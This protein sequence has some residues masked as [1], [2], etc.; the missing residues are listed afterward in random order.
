MLCVDIVPSTSSTSVPSNSIENDNES[1]A[2]LSVSDNE[3]EYFAAA[4]VTDDA[5]TL[6]RDSNSPDIVYDDLEEITIENGMEPEKELSAKEVYKRRC[7]DAFHSLHGIFVKD[8]TS[9]RAQSKI[10]EFFKNLPDDIRVKLPRDARTL[11]PPKIKFT[12]RIVPP[13]ELTYFGI[14]N[15]LNYAGDVLFDSK[16][17]TISLRCNMD[18]VPLTKTVKGKKFWPILGNIDEYPVFVIAAYEGCHE[19]LCGNDYLRDFVSEVVKL[20]NQGCTVKGRV[21]RFRLLCIIC[22]S[23]AT[24]LVTGVKNHGGYYACRRCRTMGENLQLG[25]KNSAGK[26]K[27]SVRYPEIG[28]SS[29]TH[30]DFVEYARANTDPHARPDECCF[31]QEQKRIAEEKSNICD[32][33]YIYDLEEGGFRTYVE[34]EDGEY[35]AVNDEDDA[36]IAHDEDNQALFDKDKQIEDA[37]VRN[38]DN[39]DEKVVPMTSGTKRPG[40]DLSVGATRKKSK[41]GVNRRVSKRLQYHLHPTILVEIPGFDCVRD[42]ILD[43]MHFVLLGT[44]KKMLGRWNGTN[45]T[46]KSKYKLPKESLKL[47]SQRLIFAR[48]YCPAEFAREPD[49]LDYLSSYKGTQLRQILLYIGVVILLGV[50]SKPQLQ[51]FHLLV[52]AMRFMCRKLPPSASDSENRELVKRVADISRKLLRKFFFMGI[53]LYTA[54]FAL[55]NAHHIVHIADDYERFGIPLDSLSS[56]RYENANG[57]L[58]NL[59]TGHFQALSQ[60]ENK[61]SSMIHTKMYARSEKNKV[62]NSVEEYYEIPQLCHPILGN[63]NEA[64]EQMEAGRGF[65][66]DCVRLQGYKEMRLRNFKLRTDNERDCHIFMSGPEGQSFLRLKKILKDLDTDEI[67]LVG[68]KYLRKRPLFSLNDQ[69]FPSVNSQTA[70]IV[71]CDKLSNHLSTFSLSELN[72]KCFALPL[73]LMPSSL[74]KPG[75]EWVC[76][77]YLH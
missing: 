64:V 47:I 65:P 77:R 59:I 75:S 23:P 48:E 70:G 16:S 11:R 17:N 63:D 42:C 3:L 74:M 4:S 9:L 56:F 40:D 68:Y 52:V 18:G 37:A 27:N 8:G 24:C 44:L 45:L 26:P 20:T 34:G 51:H 41:C 25:G 36:H 55:Y 19:P 22:D 53:E 43:V 6:N 30:E 14:E 60:L 31:L 62:I 57:H 58:K 76:V 50:V 32:K 67:Y 69:G 54:N 49:P 29:R 15:T 72:E 12:R 21:Y 71:V 33:R 1:E 61:I 5:M 28:L 73:S 39:N 38:D 46:D 35:Y 13:G 7:R 66:K 10:L 2:P